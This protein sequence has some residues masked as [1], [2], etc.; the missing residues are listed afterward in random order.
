[1]I[2]NLRRAR[3]RR[4]EK[5][6]RVVMDLAGPKLRTGPMEAGPAV[7]RIRPERDVFGQVT[8]PAR[9]WLTDEEH[10]QEAPSDAAAALP[11]PAKWLSRL[12]AGVG[13]EFEDTRGSKREWT[14][15][16]VTQGGLLGVQCED[17]LCGAGDHSADRR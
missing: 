13:I 4:W 17:L 3:K 8:M 10:A 12:K 2:E 14:V 5:T 1:M 15:L 11:V 16:D 9:V 7:V 6:C